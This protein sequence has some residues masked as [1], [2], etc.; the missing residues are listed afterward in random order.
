M[1]INRETALKNAI[2]RTA[3]FDNINIDG[4]TQI[5]TDLTNSFYR[6]VIHRDKGTSI[7]EILNKQ[8]VSVNAAKSGEIYSINNNS[9]IVTIPN[10]I[11][12]NPNNML[13]EGA[14]ISIE[15][16]DLFNLNVISQ[17]EHNNDKIITIGGYEYFQTVNIEDAAIKT[18]NISK[19]QTNELNC[20]II[21]MGKWQISMED[22]TTAVLAK[23]ELVT[24]DTTLEV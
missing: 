7:I 20:Q 16:Y 15:Y 1:S 12:G 19:A 5:L 23:T 17:T 11:E 21:R 3:R 24:T 8:I 10:P 4:V 9:L 13:T 18:L 2:M 14:V 22:S 6:V